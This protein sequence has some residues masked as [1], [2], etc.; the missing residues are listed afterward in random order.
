MNRNVV[1]FT[2]LLLLSV[3]AMRSGNVCVS[4]PSEPEAMGV[5]EGAV[6]AYYKELTGGLKS[7]MEANGPTLSRRLGY[8]VPEP[9]AIIDPPPATPAALPRNMENLFKDYY[10]YGNMIA[11]IDKIYDSDAP[12]NLKFMELQEKRDFLVE[13]GF[14]AGTER[15]GG[16][17]GAIGQLKGALKKA[18]S[19]AT[20]EGAEG[21]YKIHEGTEGGATEPVPS[22]LTV[23]RVYDIDYGPDERSRRTEVALGL[24]GG[25]NLLS[26][27]AQEKMIQMRLPG[28]EE[29]VPL[30][31]DMSIP[32][33]ATIRTGM[34][35]T[36][37]QDGNGNFYRIPPKVILDVSTREYLRYRID[38]AELE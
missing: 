4:A 1:F 6:D 20:G 2:C 26:E 25:E 5:S 7:W 12:A 16:V 14:I 37:L 35:D 33:G 27:K 19:L 28:G 8:A 36:I 23:Y 15:Q 10:V 24:E 32:R 17:T 3:Q 30:K 34:G 22:G 13:N 31:E 21:E 9:G 38:K 29:W 11:E 18:K